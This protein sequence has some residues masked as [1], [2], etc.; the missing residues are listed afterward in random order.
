MKK[1]FTL[2]SAA[3]M[4]TILLASCSTS[5]KDT[6]YIIDLSVGDQAVIDSAIIDTD[7][8]NEFSPFRFIDTTAKE[9]AHINVMGI[10][11]SGHYKYSDRGINSTRIRDYYE[12]DAGNSFKIIRSNDQLGE[13]YMFLAHDETSP[14]VCT[15]DECREIATDFL[16]NITDIEN[17]TLQSTRTVSGV[18]EDSVCEYTYKFVRML[19]EYET[20]DVIYIY[21]DCRRACVHQFFCYGIG[22][23]AN[24]SLPNSFDLDSSVATIADKAFDLWVATYPAQ[25][26]ST[27]IEALTFEVEKDTCKL[28]KTPD[29]HLALSATVVVNGIGDDGR[30]EA[31]GAILIID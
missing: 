5:K 12:D 23:F 30:S 13:F 1:I 26:S 15:M 14:I 24:E 2:L 27:N 3:L 28:V 21:V 19:G 16:K 6:L 25:V 22:E 9:T 7:M 17:Y 31:L 18:A 4:C 10:T 11:Y 20:N 29:G 8:A